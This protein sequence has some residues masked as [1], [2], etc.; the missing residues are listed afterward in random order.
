MNPSLVKLLFRPLFNRATR[1]TLLGRNRDRQAPE[2]GRFT[3]SDVN[4]ILETSWRNFD[5]LAPYVPEQPTV[6][7]RMNVLLACVTLSFFRALLSAD[8]KR[9]Y[10]IELLADVAWK[11]YR[12]W[13]LLPRFIA[14]L[15]HRHP[16]KRMDAMVQMFLRF[17]FNRPGYKYEQPPAPN[18]CALF[19]MHC[20]VADYLRTQGAADLCLG[21]W[22]TLDYPLAELWSGQYNRAHTLAAGDAVCDMY[23]TAVPQQNTVPE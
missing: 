10:A 8:V 15:L 23:W 20:P 7:S 22:C 9:D 13:G 3:A 14:R 2:N 19:I 12:L 5:A 6:G 21:S 11:I 1:H 17:P 4:Q 18:T 16:Q